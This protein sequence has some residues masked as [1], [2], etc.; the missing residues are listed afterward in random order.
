[1]DNRIERI[2]SFK[3]SGKFGHYSKFYTNSSSLSYLIPPRTAIIGMLAS[4]LKIPRDEYYDLM[5]EENLSISVQI[6]QGLVI[7]KQTHSLNNL[8]SK[9]YQL[10]TSGK[11]K[12]Q[13]SQCKI[14]LLM[15]PPGGMIEY[16]IYIGGKSKNEMMRELEGA[17][18]VGNYGYGV[19]LGQRQFKAEISEIHLYKR[20]EI[21][22]LVTS[23]R[24]DTMCLKE[25]ISEMDLTSNIQLL[26]D[27]IP[28]DFRKIETRGLV[29]REPIT[30]K[31]VIFE[32]TGQRLTGEFKNCYK[33]GGSI[34]SF[35]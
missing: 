3:L 29:G 19:Y 14:E 20:E 12:F 17:L 13:H 31:D 9:Y 30:V 1:M 18:S 2:I 15:G 34:I 33:I 32:K 35:Y 8:H 5:S 6:P 21:E 22:Y 26:T 10:I 25:N 11:G 27:Q 24:V 28:I 23:D 4:I 16:I 7:R